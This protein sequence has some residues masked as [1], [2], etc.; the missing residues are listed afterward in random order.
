MTIVSAITIVGGVILVLVDRRGASV[1]ANPPAPEETRAS[2]VVSGFGRTVTVRL[3]P[4]ATYC[5]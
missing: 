5:D 2:H 1:P 4:D 3:E